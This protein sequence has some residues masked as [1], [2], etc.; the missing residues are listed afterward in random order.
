MFSFGVSA[1]A[2]GPMFA[3]GQVLKALGEPLLAIVAV[4]SPS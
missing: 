4:E 1:E 3:L 2:S